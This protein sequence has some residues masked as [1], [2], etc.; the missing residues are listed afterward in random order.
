[1]SQRDGLPKYTDAG[2][3]MVQVSPGRTRQAYEV[4]DYDGCSSVFWIKQEGDFDR[5]FDRYCKFKRAGIYIIDG[6]V[7]IVTPSES[8]LQEYEVD[9]KFDR[10]RRAEGQELSSEILDPITEKREG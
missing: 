4:L 1:M 2:R 3:I 9:W 8:E 7:G 10:I 5:W 6:V